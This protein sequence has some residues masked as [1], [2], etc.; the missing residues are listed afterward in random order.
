MTTLTSF[1]VINKFSYQNFGVGSVD[2]Y[3]YYR[4]SQFLN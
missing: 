4:I 2:K 3:Y 1:I